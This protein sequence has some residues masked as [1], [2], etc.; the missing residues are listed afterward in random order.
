MDCIILWYLKYGSTNLT[1]EVHSSWRFNVKEMPRFGIALRV[2]S[3]ND[4]LYQH[5]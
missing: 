5:F 3:V 1:P 4:T 2:I